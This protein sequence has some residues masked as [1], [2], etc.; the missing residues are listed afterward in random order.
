[1]ILCAFVFEYL[2]ESTFGK[3]Q[4]QSDALVRANQGLE[5][6]VAERRSTARQLV[7]ARRQGEAANQAKSEFLSN[8]SHE[9]RTPLNHIIGFTELVVDGHAGDL[10]P[11]QADYLDDVLTSSRHLLALVNDI[12]DLSKVEAGHF[13]LLIEPLD[14]EVLITRSVTMI[15]QR[16]MRH[17]IHVDLSLAALPKTYPGDERKIRQVLYNLLSNAAKFTPDGGR[18]EIGAGLRD[19][20]GSRDGCG[21]V[22]ISVRDSGIGLAQA[23]LERIFHP[24]EQVENS[25]SRKFEGTGLGLSLSLQLME[26][27]GG[28]IKAESEGLDQGSCFTFGWPPRTPSPK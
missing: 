8:M 3:L 12:L 1:V 27:H 13:E 17:G 20:G 6:E 24:F 23:D 18:I 26:A 4:Q 14:L 10:G 11:Q 25:A 9:L 16:T 28:W 2:R 19:N 22:W 21:E 7:I 15:S 5:A